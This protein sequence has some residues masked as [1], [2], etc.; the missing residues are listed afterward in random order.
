MKNG[1]R[2]GALIAQAHQKMKNDLTRKLEPFQV[3]T[4]Q[5]IVLNKLWGRD[6]VSQKELSER[7]HKDQPT[8]ARILDKLEQ[9]GFVRR[10]T[11]PVDKRAFSIFLT[12]EGRDTEKDLGDIAQKNL[13]LALKGI[14]AEEHEQL[15]VLLKKII[16]NME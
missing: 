1:D 14:S 10:Q 15:K 4:E 2:L 6:G 16:Q 13:D 9:K 11:H 3:T 12:E 5:W 7:C 8:T